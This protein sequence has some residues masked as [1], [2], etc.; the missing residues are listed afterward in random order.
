[1]YYPC[2][3]N[4]GGDQLRSIREADLRLC[5]RICRMLVLLCSGS[6]NKPFSYVR[7][8]VNAHLSLI[9]YFSL[10]R[11]LNRIRDDM[12][13][14][15]STAKLGNLSLE[16]DMEAIMAHSRDPD[17][18]LKVWKGWRDVTG[19]KLREKYSEFVR[20]SNIGATDN[21]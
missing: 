5:F 4:K 3:E 10:I 7:L 20:L 9:S 2:S 21:G 18:L 13:E 17:K 6:I 16:P 19:P 14:I 8:I 11:D 12:E 15:Y 1:M